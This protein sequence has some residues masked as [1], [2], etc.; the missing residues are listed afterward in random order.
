MRP[1]QTYEVKVNN[2]R[3]EWG[4]LEDDW[5]FL[6]PKKIRDPD[7]KKPADWD[8]RV[9]IDDP[10]DAKPEVCEATPLSHFASICSFFYCED[11]WKLLIIIANIKVSIQ[12]NHV[13][14]VS[15][16]FPQ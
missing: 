9:T 7:A 16:G 3:L 14:V 4:N 13:S 1:D 11:A 15:S 8:D 6:P 10:D 5:D 2:E 12:M